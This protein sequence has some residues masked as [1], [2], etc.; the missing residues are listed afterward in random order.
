MSRRAEHVR[1]V[2]ATK[3]R[4]EKV[5]AAKAQVFGLFAEANP[6]RRG[7]ALEGVLNSLFRA[8]DVLVAEDFTRK[9]GGN[10]GIVEQ[11]DGVVEIDHDLYLVEMKWWDKPLGPGE[12][13]PHINRLLVRS[14]VGGI[15]I[16]SS[17]YTPAALE[18]CRDFLQ[19]RV[20]ILCT[21]REIVDVLNCG[22]DLVACRGGEIRAA[23]LDRNPFKE[24][25][26]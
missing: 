6:Q 24:V 2:A 4:A 15:F 26:V 10:T 18:T 11:I 9:G 22:E 12:M 14:G 8:Y 16:S 21:V 1:R 5:S 25:G 7:K 19:H 17:D 20:V 3:A 23:K 13:S